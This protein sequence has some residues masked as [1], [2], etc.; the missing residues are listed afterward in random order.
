MS[1]RAVSYFY[2]ATVQILGSDGGVVRTFSDSG[3]FTDAVDLTEQ[4]KLGQV[5]KEVSSNCGTWLLK[6]QSGE[7]NFAKFT[8]SFYHCVQNLGAVGGLGMN[9]VK[10]ELRDTAT[11]K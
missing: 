2:V 1:R 5:L 3:I 7:P 8:L 10:Q 11:P 9:V 6:G 4:Q